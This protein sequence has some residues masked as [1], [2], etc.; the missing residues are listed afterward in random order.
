MDND[1]ADPDV[2]EE[3]LGLDA[4]VHEVDSITRFRTLPTVTQKTKSKYG[5]P[6]LDFTTSKILTSNEYMLAVEQLK[7]TRETAKREKQELKSQKEESKQRKK[8][9]WLEPLPKKKLQ[10]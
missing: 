9:E 5:D 3:I 4:T 7:T 2:A 8:Q 10:G 1:S 6:M